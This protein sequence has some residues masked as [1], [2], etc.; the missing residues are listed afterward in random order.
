MDN[1]LD[2]PRQYDISAILSVA[3]ELSSIVNSLGQQ[4][5][6][7]NIVASKTKQD[8]MV[9]LAAELDQLM[10]TGG[11]DDIALMAM[12]TSNAAVAP[13]NDDGSAYQANCA[14]W[15]AQFILLAAT[16]TP[17][18]AQNDLAIL[19]FKL[20]LGYGGHAVVEQA[21][22]QSI[23]HDEEALRSCVAQYCAL[24]VATV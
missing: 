11:M 4:A 3:D 14:D 18:L 19:G 21:L 7:F 9:A 22:G 1:T 6:G 2:M 15:L 24:F 13:V 12:L 8:R 10:P 16:Q 20:R 5:T 23:M 17:E